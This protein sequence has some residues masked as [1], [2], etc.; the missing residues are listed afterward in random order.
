MNL[1]NVLLN[2]IVFA[3]PILA[4]IYIFVGIKLLKQKVAGQFNYFSAL[5]FSAAIY[6]FGY[7]LSLNS[8][9]I[10]MTILARNF[11]NL[12]VIFIPTF[13]ILFV[14]QFVKKKIPDQIKYVLYIL[15][16]AIWVVY[17]TNPIHHLAFNWVELT[18]VSDY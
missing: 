11:E 6:A 18:T 10:E 9:N 1:Q 5:M 16:S 7:F 4:G 13:G 3:L 14:S 2:L 8:Q 12:G 15:S 17:I